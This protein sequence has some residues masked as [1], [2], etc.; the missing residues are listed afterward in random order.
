[1]NTIHEA[2]EAYTFSV[3]ELSPKTQQWYTQKLQVFADWCVENNLSLDELKAIHLRKFIDSLKTRISPKTKKPISTYTTHGYAQ[4]IKSFLNWCSNEEDFEEVVSTKLAAKVPMPKVEIKVIEVFSPEQIKDLLEA[5]KKEF[6][7][8]LQV[9]DKAIIAVLLDTGMRANE[10]CSLTL[11]HVFLS[12]NPKEQSYL[13]IHGKGNK[14]REVPIG[15]TARSA[16]HRYITRYRRSEHTDEKHVF[17]T[18]YGQPM[19][20]RGL[21]Q[22]FERLGA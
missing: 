8:Q 20:V 6:N 18:R 10:L 7:E 2:I 3:L 15:N 16:L 13:K 9:R 17:I 22:I 4:V 1:M 19:T 14:W 5:S 11:D 12:T 21:D